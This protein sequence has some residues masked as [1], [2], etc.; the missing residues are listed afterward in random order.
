MVNFIHNGGE[1]TTWMVYNF[2]I[3][4]TKFEVKQDF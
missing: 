1:I 3:K 2:K 4:S